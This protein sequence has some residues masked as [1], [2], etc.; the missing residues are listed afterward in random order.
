MNMMNLL[1]T[2]TEKTIKGQMKQVGNAV[3]PLLA[4]AIAEVIIT[5]IEKGGLENE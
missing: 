1:L 4:A 3:P 5:D 2:L